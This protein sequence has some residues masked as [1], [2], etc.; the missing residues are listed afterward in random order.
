MLV[1]ILVFLISLSTVI[2]IHELGH[3][4]MAKRAGILCHEFSIGMGP[5][6][7]STKKG[8]TVYAIRAIPIGGYVMMAGE[9]MD[10][11]MVKVGMEVRLQF[12]DKNHVEKIVIDPENED[13]N[14]LEEV[15][16]ERVDLKGIDDSELYI[17]A[18]RVNRDAMMIMPKREI[19]IAPHN[20]S[21]ESKTIIE[22]FLAIFAGPFMNFVLA[23][24]VFLAV[25]LY[26]GVP[27]LD[28]NTLGSVSPNYPA[29][30]VLE[31]GD[32][33]ISIEGEPTDSWTDI[34]TE[35]NGL[36]G[37]RS[38]TITYN[39]DGQVNS[40][41]IIPTLYF[42][43][44]GFHSAKETGD[45]LEIGEVAEG[46][47]AE[48]AGFQAG[49]VI[50]SIDGTPMNTWTDVVNKI[51]AISLNIPTDDNPVNVDFVVSRDGEEETLT[52]SDPYSKAFLETQNLPVVDSY[53]GIGPVYNFNFVKSVQNGFSQLKSSTMIIFTTIGLLFDSDG[54]GAGIGVGELAGPVGIFEI[55]SR[56]LEQGVIS[57][58]NWIGLLSVNLGIIN[59]LPIP[60][61]DGG[62]LVFL[63]Y[64]GVTKRKPNKKVENTLHYVMYLALMGLFIYVTFNDILRLFNIR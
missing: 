2:M 7:W 63:G 36:V 17:N 45:A 23:L 12:D 56:A 10:D 27:D 40:K 34:T 26:V 11:E 55:T 19:Q 57:L 50:V 47:K 13:Y 6:L 33:I 24:L 15:L 64:E 14:H 3:F 41:Q 25:N 30:T 16:V 38:I 29:D 48:S 31:A 8:E 44:I 62:R 53:I 54:A 60:A 46:T 35:L 61:L 42:Y 58:L 51:E 52:V 32:E 1:S 43:S 21:F 37:D 5:L 59:L 4:L 18:Y 22:R 39:R 49:D 20:R 9:E 28:N